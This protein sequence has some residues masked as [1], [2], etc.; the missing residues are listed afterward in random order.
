MQVQKALID[1]E[2]M[3]ELM[4]TPPRVIDAPGA[5]PLAVREGTVEFKEVRW[6]EGG[7]GRWCVGC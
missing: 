4:A 1:M 7:G 2:N 6:V 5:V 3:F